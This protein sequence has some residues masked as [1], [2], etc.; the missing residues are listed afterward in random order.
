[1]REK[2]T[3]G[4]EGTTGGRERML[5]MHVAH[6]CAHACAH[7]CPRMHACMHACRI[8]TKDVSLEKEKGK[9]GGDFV[10]S[11]SESDLRAH[12]HP[13]KGRGGS[14]PGIR[15]RSHRVRGRGQCPPDKGSFTPE[16]ARDRLLRERLCRILLCYI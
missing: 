11:R 16:E 12:S 9:K 14:V 5:R 13:D 3:G 8:V 1:M 10:L 15:A 4:R 7:G 6:A 2:V